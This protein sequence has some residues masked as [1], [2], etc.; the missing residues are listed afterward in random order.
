[1]DRAIILALEPLTERKTE[2]TMLAELERL[3]PALFGAL[4]DHLVTGIR[5]LPDTHL[6]SAPRMADFATWAVACGLDGF[7]EAWNSN[8]RAGHTS[9]LA[10]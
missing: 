4:L 2:R 9:E 10:A 8:R 7:E 6:T 5:Q 1:M 3:R